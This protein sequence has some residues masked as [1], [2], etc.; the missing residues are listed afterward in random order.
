MV[1]IV[2][3]CLEDFDCLFDMFGFCLLGKLMLC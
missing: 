3:Y 1:L 2:R